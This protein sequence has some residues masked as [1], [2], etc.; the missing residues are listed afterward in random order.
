MSL[1]QLEGLAHLVRLDLPADFLKVHRL[2]D[3]RVD[4]DMMAAP[5]AAQPKPEAGQQVDEVRERHIPRAVQDA[6]QQP[7]AI[8]LASE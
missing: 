2:G 4:V 6:Q 8:M 3:V 7:A 1:D 5:D